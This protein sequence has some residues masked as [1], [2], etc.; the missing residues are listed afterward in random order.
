MV[1]VCSLCVFGRKKNE[2]KWFCWL[3]V[4]W[5]GIEVSEFNLYYV[6]CMVI[7]KT[8]VYFHIKCFAR[9]PNTTRSSYKFPQNTNINRNILA[10]VEMTQWNDDNCKDKQQTDKRISFQHLRFN[11]LNPASSLVENIININWFKIQLKTHTNF[12]LLII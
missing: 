6:C 9:P 11:E 4:V 1:N 10:Y 8:C 2:H 12:V 5:V 7:S 3:V